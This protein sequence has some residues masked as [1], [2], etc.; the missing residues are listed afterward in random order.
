M[1]IGAHY[2]VPAGKGRDKHK[3]SG[4]RGMEVGEQP[5][6]KLELV[7]WVY[8]Y[9]CG[10]A[11]GRYEAS[12]AGRFKSAHGCGPHRSDL[13][14]GGL[15]LVEGICYIPGYG[16]GFGMHLVVLDILGADREEG[17]GPNV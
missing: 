17:A 7:T 6:H 2:Q 8:E 13:L 12:G 1:F 3:Q 14:P 4:F 5:I 15:G 9:G 16:V 11:A 10:A